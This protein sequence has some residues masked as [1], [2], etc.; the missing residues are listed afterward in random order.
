MS[1]GKKKILNLYAGVG[2]NRKLWGDKY[3]VTA[4]EFEQYI[5]DAYKELNPNDVVIVADAHY[6]LL[7]K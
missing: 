2:G 5:A 4:V 6:N 1:E 3:E 7:S